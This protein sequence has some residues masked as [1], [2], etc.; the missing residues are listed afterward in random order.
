M[1]CGGGGPN[2]AGRDERRSGG[3]DQETQGWVSGLVPPSFVSRVV[4][5]KGHF[6]VSEIPRA[7]ACFPD[8]QLVACDA[9]FWV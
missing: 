5:A 9:C 4:K 8:L 3:R 1:E 6:H 7:T 2:G